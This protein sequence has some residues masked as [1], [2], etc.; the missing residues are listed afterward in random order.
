MNAH[1]PVSGDYARMPKD[2]VNFLI[3]LRE[4][5]FALL[6]LMKQPDVSEEHRKGIS[7]ELTVLI[8]QIDAMLARGKAQ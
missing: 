5:F 4:T 1:N 3:L 7:F 6:E 2:F 8:D